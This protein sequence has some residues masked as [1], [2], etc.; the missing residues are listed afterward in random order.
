M[1]HIFQYFNI[2]I[3]AGG[4]HGEKESIKDIVLH[5]LMDHVIQSGFIAKINDLFFKTKLLG[6]FD[7]RITKN[8]L[9]M[10][11]AALLCL[12][13]FIPVAR[14]SKKAL[15]AQKFCPMRI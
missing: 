14:I 9:M 12:I 2:Y 1:Y 4:G 8:I 7:L 15:Y 13:I 10:W 5:H 3:S 11:L 6:V